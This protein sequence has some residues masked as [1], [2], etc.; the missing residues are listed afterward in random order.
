MLLFQII[1]TVPNNQNILAWDASWYNSIR[2]NGYVYL[3]GRTCNMA[4]FPLFP[5]IW[6]L[7]TVG[8]V[9]MAG[10]N[11]II[12]AASFAW[13]TKATAVSRT[14]LLLLLSLPSL[15]FCFLPYSEAL[16]FLFGVITI[17]G[18][19]SQSRLLTCIGLMGCC[20]TRSASA[21][22]VPALIIVMI[23]EWRHKNRIIVDT[24]IYCAICIACILLVAYMQA[25]TTGLWFYFLKVQIYWD[26]QW[27]IPGLPFTTFSPGRILQYDAGALLLGML[28]IYFSIKFF[29]SRRVHVAPSVLFSLLCMA[30]ITIL[31][32]FFTHNRYGH[33]NLWSLNRHLLCAP[34]ITWLLIWFWRRYEVSKTDVFFISSVTIACL[35]LTGISRYFLAG[36]YF[37]CFATTYILLKFSWE[38]NRYRLVM[39]VINLLFQAY[40]F[41]EF[42]EGKYVA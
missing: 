6:K 42:L 32:V 5:M 31:D 21:V 29:F 14:D 2:A 19:D 9:G 37:V 33:G 40:L 1:M 41:A 12:F 28:S 3:P 24:C 39:Y 15:I 26:R 11:L 17:R 4:F 22:F 20:L 34:F 10:I 30:G 8:G 23:V 36:L 16:F 25:S 18:F 35:V 38:L 27:I 13:L 7:L